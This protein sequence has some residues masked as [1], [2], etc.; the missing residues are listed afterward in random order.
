LPFFE[1]VEEQRRNNVAHDARR[2]E[3]FTRA[4]ETMGRGIG[5]TAFAGS[6]SDECQFWPE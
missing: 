6:A 4:R 1:R 5:R 2:I 3:H